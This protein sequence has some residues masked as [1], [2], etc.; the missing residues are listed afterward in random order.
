[1]KLI[2][3]E[4]PFYRPLWRRIAIVAVCAIWAGVEASRGAYGWAAF[5]GA[6]AAY[7]AWALLWR[8]GGG[9]RR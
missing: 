2:D 4:H 9:T 3:P 7:S 6:I 8:A 1:M 5:F